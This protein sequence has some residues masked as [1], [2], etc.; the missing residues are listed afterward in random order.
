LGKRSAKNDKPIT[1]DNIGNVVDNDP[2]KNASEKTVI[3]KNLPD[4]ATEELLEKF[5]KDE[6]PGLMISNIRLVK[7]RRGRGKN[8]AFIDF[9]TTKSAQECVRSI[10]L[11]SFK[12]NE[13]TCA[14]SKPPSLG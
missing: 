4:T 3:V 11:K 7:D 10:H 8:L 1:I 14:I 2:R 13:V 9:P 12:G 6:N 5:I